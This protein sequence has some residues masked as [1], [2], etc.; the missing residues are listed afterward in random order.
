MTPKAWREHERTAHAAHQYVTDAS[1]GIHNQDKRDPAAVFMAGVIASILALV[2]VTAA[3]VRELRRIRRVLEAGG[4][5][6]PDNSVVRF[7]LTVALVPKEGE[8]PVPLPPFNPSD[9]QDVLAKIAP[10]NAAGQPCVGPFDWKSS[11]TSKVAVQPSADFLSCLCVCTPGV[12]LDV[13]VSVSQA[14]TGITATFQIQRTAPPPPDNNV[15]ELNLS[16]DLV[17]KTP[18]P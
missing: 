9:T 3:G 4:S 11:D 12:D 17:D 10:V 14:S 15:V 8:Q 6:P 5:H 2:G 1:E 16:G 7:N 18:T 13:V